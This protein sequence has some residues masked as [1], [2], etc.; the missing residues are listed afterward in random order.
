MHSKLFNKIHLIPL[1]KF[2]FFPFNSFVCICNL[3]YIFTIFLSSLLLLY[4]FDYSINRLSSSKCLMKWL[5]CVIAMTN[6]T[7]TNYVFVLLMRIYIYSKYRQNL[8]SGQM[9]RKFTL[10]RFAVHTH[11]QNMRGNRTDHASKRQIIVFSVENDFFCCWCL[12]LHIR[13][14]LA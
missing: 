8:H 1:S 2:S 11:T 10:S 12:H 7:I 6:W 3:D 14:W 13:K 4:S 5:G 9:G